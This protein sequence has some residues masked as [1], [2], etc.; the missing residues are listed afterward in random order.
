MLRIPDFTK[1]SEAAEL[2][3]DYSIGGHELTEAL[4]QLRRINLLLGAAFPLLEG[5]MYWWRQAGQPSCLTILDVGAGSGDLN[6]LLL[7]W[8]T[9]RRVHLRITL[10]DIHP[11]TCAVAAAY[12]HDE[13]RIQVQQGDVFT[14]PPQCADIV[15][16]SLFTHH[17]PD[18]QLPAVVAALTRAARVGVVINDLERHPVAWASIWLLT[19]LFSRNRMICHDAPLS[20]RRGFRRPDFE[21]LRAYPGLTRLHYRWRPLFRYLVTLPG[22][23]GV[24]V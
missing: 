20:V 14:L 23:A 9:L 5:V 13:P 17:F 18:P 10:L 21:R 19:R 12:Y 1:R 7:R 22:S 3:D 8:A 24:S 16:A 6:H 2:M 11:D 4:A 15:T